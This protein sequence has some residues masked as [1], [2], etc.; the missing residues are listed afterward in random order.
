MGKLFE[1]RRCSGTGRHHEV[2]VGGKEISDIEA[3]AQGSSL[4]EDA[5]QACAQCASLAD[6]IH[7]AEAQ[8]TKVRSKGS[9]PCAV[10]Y[11][12]GSWCSFWGSMEVGRGTLA[13]HD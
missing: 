5:H 11:L 9:T 13:V 7:T 2:H 4:E 10:P 12:A 6:E 8:C 3:C 1:S